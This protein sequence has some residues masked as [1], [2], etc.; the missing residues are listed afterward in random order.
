MDSN[1]KT[2]VAEE[3]SNNEHG[4]L[5]AVTCYDDN[6]NVVKDDMVWDIQMPYLEKDCKDNGWEL[7][8]RHGS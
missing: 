2:V 3:I 5:Y 7:I 6:K 1:I 4:Y 8:Y